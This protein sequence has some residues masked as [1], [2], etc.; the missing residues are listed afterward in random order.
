MRIIP[1]LQEY[2]SYL[3]PEDLD[4]IERSILHDACQDDTCEHNI[5]HN[6]LFKNHLPHETKVTR[7]FYNC[8][9]CLS[10]E[11]TEYEIAKIYD[12]KDWSVHMLI[13]SGLNKLSKKKIFMEDLRD[14]LEPESISINDAIAE[15][16]QNMHY[17]E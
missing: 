5:L 14:T 13:K 6:T 11:L 4:F 12:I 15:F 8:L 1:C 16:Q 17:E 7:E 10:R 9:C 3:L 2:E